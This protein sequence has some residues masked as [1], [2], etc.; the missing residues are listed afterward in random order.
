[1]NSK[2][3]YLRSVSFEEISFRIS[4][5]QFPGL[6]RVEKNNNNNH[7]C[8]DQIP[9]QKAVIIVTFMRSGSTFLGEI[10]NVHKDAFYMFEPLHQWSEQGWF[11]TKTIQYMFLKKKHKK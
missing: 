11:R 9:L 3:K 6:S 8:N 10:F 4:N 7:I 2:L 5:A 1:M